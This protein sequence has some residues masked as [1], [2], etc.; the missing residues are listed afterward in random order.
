MGEGKNGLKVAYIRQA[1]EDS[2]QRLQT[3]YIDL[4]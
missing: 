1:V 4:Y 2:L 3:D